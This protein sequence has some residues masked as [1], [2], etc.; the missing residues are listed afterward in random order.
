MNKIEFKDFGKWGK[1][2][3]EKEMKVFEKQIF[4]TFKKTITTIYN[5]LKQSYETCILK[6]EDASKSKIKRINT[7]LVFEDH[8]EGITAKIVAKSEVE[9]NILYIQSHGS[10][11]GVNSEILEYYQVSD[12]KITTEDGEATE[13]SNW[14]FKP[15][16]VHEKFISNLSRIYKTRMV[17][18]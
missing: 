16:G 7:T 8:P 10:G 4:E 15:S 5:T 13:I 3:L 12:D 1:N 2:I 9:K 18:K 17:K 14:Y 11:L 6:N